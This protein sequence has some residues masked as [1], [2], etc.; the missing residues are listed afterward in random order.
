MFTILGLLGALLAGVTADAL[1]S[2]RQE[3]DDDEDQ[4]N[5]PEETGDGGN[6]LDDLD[7]QTGGQD[8]SPVS[9]DFDDP[10]ED[11]QDITG[12]AAN[13]ILSGGQ[14]DDA[15]RGEGGSD[16]IDGR[17]G[18]DSIEAG[19]GNDFVSAGS[20]A[21]TVDGGDG[22][23][24]IEGQ[25]G[26]DSLVGGTG[27]DALA[28]HEGDDS[29]LGQA[30]A[31]TL[32]GGTGSDVLDGGTGDD[33]LAGGEGNDRVFGAA[34]SDVLDGN[35]GDDWISGLQGDVDDFDAD[36]LNGGT[37]NDSLVLGSGDFATGGDGD[38]DFVL[39]EWLTEGGVAH[40]DDYDAARDQL[41]I[42]YDPAAHPDPALTLELSPDGAQSTVL[43]DGAPVA[44]VRGSP[45]ILS[46]IQL[47]AA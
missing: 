46:D 22:N 29:L 39:Q 26:D 3:T 6:L 18:D 36:F 32:T 8:R 7:G 14:G 1:M 4:A 38:D 24:R 33:W 45:I 13:D 23:D 41:I 42:A 16:L 44:T 2:S 15:I 17:D 25:A 20:G 12:D 47:K 28:G 40:I 27:N 10:V 35:A 34:G 37:G 43:L 9:D 19:S 5:G 30:G 11:G 21:D 31:D